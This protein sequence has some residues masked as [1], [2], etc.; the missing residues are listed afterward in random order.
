METFLAAVFG[1]DLAFEPDSSSSTVP[2]A[3]SGKLSS[4]RSTLAICKRPAA[5]VFEAIRPS[6]LMLIRLFQ[7][8]ARSSVGECLVRPF[9][10]GC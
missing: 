5:T 8:T 6:V 1:A 10:A 4:P 7:L 3:A 2:P 9:L